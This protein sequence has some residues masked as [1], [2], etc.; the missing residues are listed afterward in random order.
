[1]TFNLSAS[2]SFIAATDIGKD[3]R[4]KLTAANTVGIAGATE[5]YIGLTETPTKAGRA[6][7]VRLK[8]SGGTAFAIAAGAFA[9][10]ATVYGVADGK[11]DDVS[12]DNVVAGVALTAATA[13]G[14]TIELLLP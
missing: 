12:T 6:V 3:I 10:N 11:V 2:R 7:S 1:M 14:D 13:D 4:V 9:V 8:N 5:D